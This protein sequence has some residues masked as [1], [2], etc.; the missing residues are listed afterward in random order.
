MICT[1]RIIIYKSRTSNEQNKKSRL[2]GIFLF[3]AEKL[4]M[5]QLL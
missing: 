4:F 2:G 5:Q 3:K 1:D